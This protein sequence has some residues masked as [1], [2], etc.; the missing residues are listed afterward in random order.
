MNTCNE[1]SAWL[2]VHKRSLEP[3]NSTAS[4]CD[5]PTRIRHLKPPLTPLLEEAQDKLCRGPPDH[6]HRH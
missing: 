1:W 4:S 5:L 2:Q 6:M 3:A